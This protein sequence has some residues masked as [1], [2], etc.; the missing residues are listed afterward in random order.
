MVDRLERATAACWRPPS[1]AAIG[2][3][4]HAA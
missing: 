2:G 1:I 3:R 4:R